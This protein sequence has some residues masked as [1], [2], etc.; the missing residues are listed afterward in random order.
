MM[1]NLQYEIEKNCKFYH[2][3]FNHEFLIIKFILFL[4]KSWKLNF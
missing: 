4:L 1:Q 2:Y 3:D